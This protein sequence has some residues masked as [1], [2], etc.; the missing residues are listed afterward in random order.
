MKKKHERKY[1]INSNDWTKAIVSLLEVNQTQQTIIVKF[2]KKS[3]ISDYS[4]CIC[5]LSPLLEMPENVTKILCDF[6]QA[7]ILENK[8]LYIVFSDIESGPTLDENNHLVISKLSN[9][10]ITL[11]DNEAIGLLKKDA[12][13]TRKLIDWIV[14]IVDEVIPIQFLQQA[15]I[16]SNSEDTIKEEDLQFMRKKEKESSFP[17]TNSKASFSYITMP[18]VWLYTFL[19]VI[20]FIEISSL[21]SFSKDLWFTI[22]NIIVLIS[23]NIFIGNAIYSFIVFDNKVSKTIIVKLS[24]AIVALILSLILFSYN[25]ITATLLICIVVIIFSLLVS[26]QMTK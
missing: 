22:Y 8:K 24:I 21:L 9:S 15:S 13:D 12:E 6:P 17:H 23:K 26:K 18:R 2:F 5:P 14:P 20:S 4:I 1:V 19:F 11:K 10:P 7:E 3:D 25:A 16:D